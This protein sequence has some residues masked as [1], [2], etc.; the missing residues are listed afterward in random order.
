MTQFFVFPSILLT[1]LGH[2]DF[3]R[4]FCLFVIFYNLLTSFTKMFQMNVW[5]QKAFFLFSSSDNVK[6]S[7]DR[8]SHIN[9]F[10]FFLMFYR[11]EIYFF[12]RHN[13]NKNKYFSYVGFY[14]YVL[15]YHIKT[16]IPFAMHMFSHVLLSGFIDGILISFFIVL[17]KIFSKW[18]ICYTNNKILLQI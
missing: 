1:H 11:L 9:K 12:P 6:W 2:L 3:Y 16:F 14:I 10:V 7:F 17:F 8:I 13:S 5:K 18:S 4:V 15:T